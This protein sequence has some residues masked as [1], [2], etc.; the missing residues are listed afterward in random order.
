MQ[1]QFDDGTCFH[2]QNL[3]KR[4]FL[5]KNIYFIFIEYPS[6]VLSLSD[7]RITGLLDYWIVG[8]SGGRIIGLTPKCL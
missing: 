2:T 4:T 8:Q 5:I 6:N 1:R 3:T 7:Y